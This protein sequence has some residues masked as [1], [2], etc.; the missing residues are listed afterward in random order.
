MIFERVTSERSVRSS[1]EEEHRLLTSVPE[2]EIGDDEAEGDS[3]GHVPEVSGAMSVTASKSSSNSIP[4]L[5]P[6]K[7]REP[8][9]D[10]RKLGVDVEY[11]TSAW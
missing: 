3:N 1:R 5:P 4:P 8:Y 6:A 10:R 7:K 11:H 2:E 9:G